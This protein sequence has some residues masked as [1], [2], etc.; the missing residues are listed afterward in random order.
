MSVTA[1]RTSKIEGKEVVEYQ[2]EAH[3]QE[4]ALGPGVP[5]SYAASWHRYT[6]FAEMHERIAP[7]LGLGPFPV[8]KVRGPHAQCPARTTPRRSRSARPATLPCFESGAH[9]P[10][11]A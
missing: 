10:A 8:P 2:L 5:K 9:L 4:L 3:A 1:H 7:G 11:R 6:D